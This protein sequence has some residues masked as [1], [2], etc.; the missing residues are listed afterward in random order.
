[1]EITEVRVKLMGQRNDK[2]R[3][4]CSV[5]FDAALVIHDLKVIE[6]TKGAFVAMPSRKLTDRCPRCGGKNHLQAQYCNDCGRNLPSG[7]TTK[8]ARGRPKLHADVAHPINS[9][10]RE[11]L[12]ER[13]LRAFQ[14]EVGR[15][16]LPGYRPPTFADAPG[17]YE[18]SGGTDPAPARIAAVST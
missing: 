15:S 1:M 6:G 16:Q 18:E 12:Q 10:Y 8:D 2:L 17:D 9:A 3:A 7:R 13:V 4:L 5:T 14:E 11:L